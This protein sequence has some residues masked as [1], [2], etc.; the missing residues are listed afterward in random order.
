MFSQNGI[1]Y[2]EEHTIS[3]GSVSNNTFTEVAN[4]WTTWHLIP[5]TRPTVSQPD[6]VFKFV[7]I[8]GKQGKEDFSDFLLNGPQ[9]GH[10]TGSWSFI[11][12]PGFTDPAIL[13]SN[14]ANALHGKRLKIKLQDD[15]NYYYEGRLNVGTLESGQQYSTI[16][17]TYELDP[18]KKL[19]S[20]QGTGASL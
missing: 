9:Y 1:Y 16:T 12:V 6:P 11:V 4:T 13:R 2:S 20:P 15:P 7:D 17:I 10:R 3:F 8:P 19:I 18:Y 5:S 14:I